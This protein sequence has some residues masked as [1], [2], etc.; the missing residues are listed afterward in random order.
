MKD[1]VAYSGKKVVELIKSKEISCV[2]VMQA[3]LERIAEINP[4]INSVV[5]Q[6]K[7]DEALRLAQQ[8]DDDVAKQKTLGVLHGLPVTIKDA[9]QVKGFFCTFGTESPMNF[10]AQ[11]DATVVA[12]LKNAGAIITGINNIPDFSMTYDTDCALYGR[13]NNPYDLARSPGGSSGAV[14]ATIA[15]GGAYFSI[16]SDA[17]GSI[18]QPAHNCGITG[19]KPT[20]RSVPDTGLFPKT[21]SEGLFYQIGTQGPMARYVEDLIQVLPLIVGPDDQDPHVV[22]VHCRDPQRVNLKSLRV[23]TYTDNGVVTP[24][25]D[26]VNAIQLVAKKLESEVAIVEER[27]PIV[28][29]EHFT[30]FEELFFYGDKGL[31]LTERMEKMGV[32]KVAPP[33]KVMLERAKQSS[34]SAT[35][36]RNRLSLVE[37]FKFYM[38]EYMHNFDVIICPVATTP[39]NLYE[40]KEAITERFDLAYD[41]TYNIPYNMMGWPA[42][43]VRCGTSK[44]GL[45]IGVQIVAKSWREDIVLAVA[46]RVE[47]LFGGWKAPLI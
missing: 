42:A 43:S 17:G 19:I 22:P 41:L 6:L 23:L 28:S 12:R 7:P 15:A 13:S 25:E 46:K 36:M 2:E 10:T 34:F 39:A 5:Q 26:V 29:K 20:L 11:K 31:W 3:H 4:S 44:E 30:W 38:M 9:R 24:R 14:A 27:F 37:Q 45:P 21:G 47:E 33:F 18:R 32:T 40:V 16:G 8:A 1:L 35:E